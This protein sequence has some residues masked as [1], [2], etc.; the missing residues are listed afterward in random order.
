[1]LLASR[2]EVN[3]PRSSTGIKLADAI[4][5]TNQDAFAVPLPSTDFAAKKLRREQD[6]YEKRWGKEATRDLVWRVQMRD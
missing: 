2:R 5:P 1:M 6:E 3:A 4:D